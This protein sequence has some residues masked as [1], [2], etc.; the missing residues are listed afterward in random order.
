[1]NRLWVYS[2]RPSESAYLLAHTEGF[3]RMVKGKF[4]KPDD[5]IVNWGNGN[6]V[7]ATATKK[8][9]NQPAAICL[10]VNKLL[11]FQVL[12]GAGVQVPLWTANPAVAKEWQAKERTI[13]ARKVL[14]GHEGAG[15]VIIEPGADLVQAPL[16]TQ[17]IFKVKEFRVHATRLK[18]FGTHQKIRDPDREPTSWKVRSWKNGFIFQRNNIKV[19]AARDALAVAAINA[20]GLDF[21]AVDI[22]EDKNGNFYVLE[23]NTAPGIEGVSVPM[24]SNA[25][26]ELANG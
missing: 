20:L 3:K 18:A 1:M 22:I 9:F 23:V 21:G 10:A 2:G 13:V 12:S 19:N 7:P 5:T 24:Y 8:I 17:Y 4:V 6:S 14:T 25:L 11:T 26:K 15:I 16:Y